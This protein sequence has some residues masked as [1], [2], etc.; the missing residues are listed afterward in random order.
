MPAFCAHCTFKCTYAY[1][2]KEVVAG[3]LFF[4]PIVF[5]FPSF[6]YRDCSGLEGDIKEFTPRSRRVRFLLKYIYIY[7]KLIFLT[8]D[9]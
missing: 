4:F 9:I 1:D 5:C 2:V 6:I 3:K 8:S 7:K